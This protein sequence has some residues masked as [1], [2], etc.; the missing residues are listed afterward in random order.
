MKCR[1]SWRLQNPF[2]CYYERCHVCMK[3]EANVHGAG[4]SERCLHWSPSL[5]Q[6]HLMQ[7][8]QI[9]SKQ[10]RDAFLIRYCR[11]PA[12]AVLTGMDA[13]AS[14][15]LKGANYRDKTPDLSRS[16]K[17]LVSRIPRC[18]SWCDGLGLW[19]DC[20]RHVSTGHQVI[21]RTVDFWQFPNALFFWRTGGGA[22]VMDSF[23]MGATRQDT[24]I[25]WNLDVEMDG[26]AD[27][28][29]LGAKPKESSRIFHTFDCWSG[30]FKDCPLGLF[31]SFI[32]Y[33]MFPQRCVQFHGRIEL[34]V[35]RISFWSSRCRKPRMR[36]RCGYVKHGW[37]TVDRIN[38]AECSWFGWILQV[39]QRLL[40]FRPLLQIDL[41]KTGSVVT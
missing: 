9:L 22:S 32:F 16:F 13:A 23:A 12:K 3:Y 30:T 18:H 39:S 33:R 41:R 17:W 34:L 14:H 2:P 1:I 20:C 6:K 36:R 29:D 4:F 7:G 40:D 11:R 35:L 38:F 31:L 27:V 25:F 8:C 15:C 5:V 19:G 26:S 10:K 21:K 24:D 37:Q 28:K